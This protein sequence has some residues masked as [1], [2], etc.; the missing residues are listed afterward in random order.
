MIVVYDKDTG[1]ILRT[2]SRASKEQIDE[3]EDGQDYLLLDP[4]KRAAPA[5]QRVDVKNKE[6]VDIP[7]SEKEE[8]RRKARGREKERK[9]PLQELEARVAALEKKINGN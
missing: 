2:C 1:D 7:E 3:I 8:R 5:R 9:T 4:G 6:V